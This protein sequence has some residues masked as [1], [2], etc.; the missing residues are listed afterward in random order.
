MNEEEWTLLDFN[1]NQSHAIPNNK[2]TVSI[3]DKNTRRITLNKAITKKIREEGFCYL[4]VF[5]SNVCA[6]AKFVFRKKQ[7]P[8]SLTITPGKNSRTIINSKFL[9][10]KMMEKMALPKRTQRL[11]VSDNIS[12]SPE[13]ATYRIT[14]A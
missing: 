3:D 5:L 8:D 6:E 7:S 14:K 2:I 11:T 1:G 12:N 4:S 10:E 9:V 13:Y